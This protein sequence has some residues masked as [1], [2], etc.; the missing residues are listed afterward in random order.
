MKILCCCWCDGSCL[1]VASYFGVDCVGHVTHLN[2]CYLSLCLQIVSTMKSTFDIEKGCHL[3]IQM[4]FRCDIT[5]KRNDVDKNGCLTKCIIFIQHNTER[6]FIRSFYTFAVIYIQQARDSS[7]S[8]QLVARFKF[9]WWDNC[10]FKTS[11]KLSEVYSFF[12]L[13]FPLP[14]KFR[15]T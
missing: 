2:R 3:L 13:W 1:L 12:I 8:S 14:N 15:L 11:E 9:Y 5:E 7:I 10:N 6:A 4:Y